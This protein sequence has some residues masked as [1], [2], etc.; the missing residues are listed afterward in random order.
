MK[1]GIL[2]ETKSLIDV[3]SDDEIEFLLL[4]VIKSFSCR[5]DGISIELSDALISI[6]EENISEN[7]KIN[8]IYTF[9]EAMGKIN[10]LEYSE[11]IILLYLLLKYNRITDII[12]DIYL[13][14]K[15][16]MHIIVDKLS[17]TPAQI[18]S[19]KTLV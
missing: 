10:A 8:K 4:K 13:D 14:N 16:I 19:M 5:I 3:E 11:L 1:N 9:I 18:Y 17:L 15:E 6:F 12:D 2:E 7:H